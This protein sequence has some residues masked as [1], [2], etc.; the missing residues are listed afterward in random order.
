MP[1]Y[2][3]P[4]HR[5]R[6]DRFLERMEPGSVA[7]FPTAPESRRVND[8]EFPY[9]ADTDFFYLTGF[10]EP[11]AVAV[12]AK[13]QGDVTYT[14]FVRKRDPEMETWTGRRAGPDGA[15][16]R[17][18][19][20]EAF[21]LDE[22]DEKLPRILANASALYYVQGRYADWDRRMIGLLDGLRRRQKHKEYPPR[23]QIDPTTILQ[24]L[25]LTKTPDEIE[26]LRRAVT[27]SAEAHREVMAATRPGMHEYELQAVIEYVFRK[28]NCEPGYTTIVGAGENATVLHYVT[29]DCRIGE[30]EL[31]LVDAGA[32]GPALFTGDI[33]RTFPS[34]GTFTAAQRDVYEMVL[35]AQKKA[36]EAVKPGA[37]LDDDIHGF[38]L[39]LLVEGMIRLELLQGD[40]D[41]IIEKKEYEKYYMHRTSHW[42]GM[43]VHDIGDYYVGGDPR[44]L[45]AGMVITVEP[46]I[47]IP[48][49]AKD[50]P[51][52]FRGMG[53]RIEDDVLVTAD[54]CDVLSA[55]APKEIADIEEQM[56]EKSI[57]V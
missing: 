38:T 55:D 15:K 52:A 21:V 44:R 3:A 7:V 18:G 46:G 6:R 49:D 4:L 17:F 2:D 37:T 14:L 10:G 13:D 19:A 29:N 20:D 48:P 54:G 50:A 9:R 36:I 30:D 34:G 53:I 11:D 8:T 32:E 42:L 39:R 51:E 41:E 45:E 1:T 33:T 26:W 47:Y 25:R 35:D 24:D 16:E 57:F 12:L 5:A 56:A 40:V 28:H 43:D 27:V 31:I 22:L 23:T